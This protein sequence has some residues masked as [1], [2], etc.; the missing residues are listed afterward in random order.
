M[1]NKPGLQNELKALQVD[2]DRNGQEMMSLLSNLELSWEDQ[3]I[4]KMR[5]L[6]DAIRQASEQ[7]IIKQ[8]QDFLQQ[9]RDINGQIIDITKSKESIESKML[10]EVDEQDLVNLQI[11]HSKLISDYE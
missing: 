3:Y 7:S 8:V 5:E 6:N 4:I 2:A 1:L 10:V 9:I 11:I